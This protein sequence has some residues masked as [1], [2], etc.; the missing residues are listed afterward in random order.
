MKIVFLGTP[1]FALKSLQALY[2]NGNEILAVVTNQDK[3]KGRGMKLIVSPVKEF[4]VEKNI[5][6][7]QPLK[8]RDNTEFINEIKDLNPDLLCVVAYGK[9]LPKELLDVPKYGSINV[10]GSLL[11]KYRGAAPI[12][13]AVLNGDK[14]TGIT[15]MFMDEGMDTGDMIFKEK[16]T[17]GEDETTGELW[18]RL[19]DIGANLL[20]KTVNK[21]DE[22]TKEIMLE[23]KT[24]SNKD[25]VQAPSEEEKKAIDNESMEQSCEEVTKSNNEA[26]QKLNKAKLIEQ[27]KEKIGAQ[28]QEGDFTLAPMLNKEMAQIDWNKSA[29][30]IKNLVRGLNP[31][32]GAYTFIDGKKIKI[33]KV[34]ALE[35]LQEAEN[36]QVGEIIIADRKRGLFIKTGNGVI[37]VLEVQGENG[38]KM[39]I[40]SFL[41]G[42]HI[43]VGKV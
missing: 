3:P 29:Q 17:I 40:K 35:N 28:K 4:A 22:I 6:V 21:I 39:D 26:T 32:M 12:Q 38:K 11:P 43:E 31:I 10:H 5:R 18:D 33:W 24:L 16:V 23:E 2:E 19:A 30:E 41:N 13:W 36:K 9:I 8:V 27:I 15:T 1:D 34:N 42:N 7:M 25:V 14:E 20:V 37:E